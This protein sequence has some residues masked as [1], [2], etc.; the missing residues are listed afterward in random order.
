MPG[1]KD[2]PSSMISTPS[3]VLSRIEILG[4]I[5]V[6]IIGVL[7]ALPELKKT[8]AGVILSGKC[9]R[10]PEPAECIPLPGPGV[11]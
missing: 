4:L 6:I 11:P 3:P 1:K 7:F 8:T 2:A 9:D 5:V 10:D